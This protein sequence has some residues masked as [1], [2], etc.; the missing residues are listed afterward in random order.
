VDELANVFFKIEGL[1][2]FASV[3]AGQVESPLPT[4][5]IIHTL[6]L[7]HCIPTTMTTT[8]TLTPSSFDLLRTRPHHQDTSAIFDLDDLLA[9]LAKANNLA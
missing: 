1:D 9:S 6:L 2:Q 3:T 7:H 4:H 8:T 5:H